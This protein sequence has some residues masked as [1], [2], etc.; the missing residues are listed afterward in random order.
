MPG[1]S[2]QPPKRETLYTPRFL[3]PGILLLPVVFLPSAIILSAVITSKLNGPFPLVMVGLAT[4]T[5]LGI[6]IYWLR[7]VHQ[8]RKLI[9]I[10]GR[11]LCL[12]CHYPLTGLA[13]QG[14][15]P[16]CDHPYDRPTNERR[17]R[18][19]EEDVN[20]GKPLA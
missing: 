20:K 6:V 7:R 18:S 13:D 9:R 5:I 3:H 19:W 12:N 15:C 10:H 17:W 4:A 14:R 8:V 1:P 2:D 11:F 16:E